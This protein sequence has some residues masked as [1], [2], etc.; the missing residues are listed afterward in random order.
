MSERVNRAQKLKYW[1]NSTINILSF[2][3]FHMTSAF[4]PPGSGHPRDVFLNIYDTI[5]LPVHKSRCAF[6]LCFLHGVSKLRPKNTWK[7]LKIRV[8]G[9]F[10]R[11]T[12]WK[13][14]PYGVVGTL[15]GWV[16]SR[17][18]TWGRPT[19]VDGSKQASKI[20]RLSIFRNF[21]HLCNLF[22]SRS[23]KTAYKGSW[24][25]VSAKR[26]YVWARAPLRIGR[27]N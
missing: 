19:R 12:E 4:V 25:N 21:N 27:E 7:H 23:E 16:V 9:F 13:L 24:H 1:Q 5:C 6:L 8:F 18:H 11:K 14:K 26:L 20:W 17:A 15:I 3:E 10:S 22:H 2:R